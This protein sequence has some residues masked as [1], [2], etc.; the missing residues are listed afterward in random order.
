MEENS[1]IKQFKIIDALDISTVV[2]L[3]NEN[4]INK[5]PKFTIQRLDYDEKIKGNA[6]HRTFFVEAPTKKNKDIVILSFERNKVVVN[7]GILEPEQIKIFKKSKNMKYTPVYKETD[8]EE[9]IFEYTSD[10]KRSVCIIDPVTGDEIKPE[11]FIDEKTNMPKGKY[12]L[13]PFKSYFLF[14]IPNANDKG[15]K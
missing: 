9:K 7:N 5:V 1:N 4:I 6:R 8:C 14:E 12:T 2:Y 3:V 15:K 13:N 10:F 11:I